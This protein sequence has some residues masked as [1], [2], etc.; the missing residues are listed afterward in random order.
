LTI[1]ALVEWAS[2][3]IF[4]FFFLLPCR[5]RLLW[6]SW[7]WCL[8]TWALMLYLINLLIQSLQHSHYL[9]YLDVRLNYRLF[10]WLCTSYLVQYYSF[11][12]FKNSLALYN[13]STSLHWVFVSKLDVRSFHTINQIWSRFIYQNFKLH[14]LFIQ[15]IIVTL[16]LFKFFP[17][18][19]QNLL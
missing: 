9:C 10:A 12:L 11:S 7:R 16:H 6:F 15:M 3:V 13:I 19:S 1:V 18:F 5:I 2:E 4:I 14:S 17:F 8:T